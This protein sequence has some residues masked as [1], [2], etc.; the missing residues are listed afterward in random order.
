MKR[1]LLMILVA[2]ALCVGC[3][4]TPEQEDPHRFEDITGPDDTGDWL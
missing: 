3:A 2:G 1:L 4:T